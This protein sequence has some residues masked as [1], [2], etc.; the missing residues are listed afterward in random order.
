VN[1]VKVHVHC[2]DSDLVL[3]SV[4]LESTSEET[5]SKVEK[6]NPEI[7]WDSSVNPFLEELK[8]VFEIFNE[9]T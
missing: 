5:M 3:S 4:V 8:S 9:T 2:I 6:V 1:H 7:L